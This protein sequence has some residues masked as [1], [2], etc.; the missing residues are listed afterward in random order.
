MFKNYNYPEKIFNQLKLIKSFAK[1]YEVVFYNLEGPL[2]DQKHFKKGTKR[3]PNPIFSY[4]VLKKLGINIVSISNNHIF[5]FG[6]D[7][8]ERSIYY[9]KEIR[10]LF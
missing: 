4:E 8:L 2:T 3:I 6:M 5:D 10:L 1:Q 7:G 9:D